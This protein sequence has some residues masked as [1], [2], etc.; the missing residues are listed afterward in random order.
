MDPTAPQ[1]V[2]RYVELVVTYHSTEPFFLKCTKLQGKKIEVLLALHSRPTD[3]LQHLGTYRKASEGE[4]IKLRSG[5]PRKMDRIAAKRGWKAT[6]PIAHPS[7]DIADEVLAPIPSDAKRLDLY[8]VLQKHW[9]DSAIT[10]GSHAEMK[11][12]EET[13]YFHFGQ[14][15][16]SLRAYTRSGQ[17]NP[18][19]KLL[20]SKGISPIERDVFM[21]NKNTPTD[22]K[23]SSTCTSAWHNLRSITP[24]TIGVPGETHTIDIPAGW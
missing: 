22:Q 19:H 6:V 24:P 13:Y 14:T 17:Q 3:K 5:L 18:T 8:R 20:R 1:L 11:P 12:P 21:T 9:W 15:K 2:N 7:W 16:S 23:T 4:S 10:S